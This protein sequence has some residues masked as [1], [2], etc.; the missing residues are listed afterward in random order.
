MNDQNVIPGHLK[1]TLYFMLQ[2]PLTDE[3]ASAFEEVLS[4]LPKRRRWVI[5]SP[6]LVDYIETDGGNN[7]EAHTYGGAVQLYS[8]LPPWGDKLPKEVD[9]AHYE[10]VSLIVDEL[11]A[12]SKRFNCDFA[13]QLDQ[14]HVGYI[15]AGLPDESIR[16]GLLGEWEKALRG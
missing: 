15:R 2:T 7:K 14:T 9:K 8:A 12:L 3:L 6:Q 1:N 11:K 4:S 5:D 13:L 10:E 16:V